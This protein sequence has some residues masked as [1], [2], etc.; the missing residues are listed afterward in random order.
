MSGKADYVVNSKFFLGMRAGVYRQNTNDFNVPNVSR[1][2]FSTSNI[3]MAGVPASEQ[4][5]SGYTNVLSN[6]AVDHDLMTRTNLQA[7][8]T[9]YAKAGGEHKI[10]VGVQGD[11]RSED[12][13]S[14]ELGH[15]VTIR[16]DRPLPSGSPLTR[17]P[18]GYYSVR[19]NAVL[20]KQGFITQGNVKSNLYGIFA[21]DSWTVNNRFT[22]NAGIRTEDERIP[23][24]TTAPGVPAYPIK[25]GFADKWA[26]RV[27]ASYDV[28]GD[29][30]W[31]VYGSW[32]VF[33]DIFKLELP[34]GSFGGQKWL[35]YYYTLDNPN[36]ETLDQGSNCPPACSGTLI[37]GPVDFR[38]VSV[39]PGEDIDANL[40]PMRSQEAAFGVEHQ[41][42]RMMAVSARFVH[43]HLDRGIEDTGARLADGSEPYIIANPGESREAAFNLQPG[44]G[45][46][47]SATGTYALP[48]PKRR[49]NGVEFAFDKRYA[50]SWFLRLSYLLSQDY[51]NYPGLS[52]SDENG[53]S[54]PNVGRL[55]DYPLIMFKGDGTPSYGVL[56]TDRTHQVKAQFLYQFPFGTSIGINQYLQSGIPITAEVSVIPPNN[57]PMQYKGRGSEGRSDAFIQTDLY[58]Q[59]EFKIGG[60]RRLQINA[61]VLN[62]F[63]QRSVQNVFTTQ[64]NGDGVTFDEAAFYAG[65]IDVPSVVT[66]SVQK[67]LVTLEPR[68]LKAN[69]YQAPLQAR[70]GVKI[71]F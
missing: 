17:G 20:P 26:P 34:Q 67:G 28:K 44:G 58:V 23:S 60:A 13:V 4:H 38:S 14:G 22:I 18:F 41:V 11:L 53:R 6:N 32:G 71:L 54:D 55:F 56:P 9:W 51:G 46:A 50:D 5:S 66:Q 42:G 57:Y 47:Y 65:K 45:I 36:F 25:F 33:Y 10:R 3:G 29:G 7:D 59:H 69:G 31:K 61:N 30:L 2:A 15:R 39:I 12:V 8:G 19:S 68:F 37:Q 43:K 49:Y 24:F 52:E 27:G 63:D 35:E 64:L 70:F 48:K 21:Q 40:K 16:W 1:F 62:L